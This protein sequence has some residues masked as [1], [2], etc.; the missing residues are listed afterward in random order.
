KEVW[1]Q[2]IRW[3]V[4]R[5]RGGSQSEPVFLHAC[6]ST[7]VTLSVTVYFLYEIILQQKVGTEDLFL[8]MSRKDPSSMCCESMLVKVKLPDTK[9]CDVTPGRLHL[10]HPVHSGEG[11]ARFITERAELEITLPMNRPMDCI[12]LA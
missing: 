4:M 7:P 6:R 8:G 3:R 9:A 10:P 5:D 1:A 11:S 12:N 2:P